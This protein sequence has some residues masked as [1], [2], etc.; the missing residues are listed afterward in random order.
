MDAPLAI[1]IM[2]NLWAGPGTGKSTT[3]AV[4]FHILKLANVRCELVTEF[5]KELTYLG[6]REELADQLWV[7]AAQEHR[8]RILVGKVDVIITDSPTGLGRAYVKKGGY[9]E[10]DLVTEMARFSRKFYTNLDFLLM[11]DPQRSLQAYGRKERTMDEAQEKDTL[12]RMTML[13]TCGEGPLATVEANPNAGK[14]V[15]QAVMAKLTEL[16][17]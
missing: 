11:R 10:R 2:V 5:A 4:V 8:C 15:T 7:S 6:R 9:K 14:V 1:P 17:R 13:H 3:A 16:G 12:V